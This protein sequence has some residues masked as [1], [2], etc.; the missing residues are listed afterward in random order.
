VNGYKNIMAKINVKDTEVTVIQI[1][2]VNYILLT[3][4]AKFKT[5]EP[6]V[7]I[8]NWMRNRNTIEYLGIWDVCI[9]LILPPEFEGV[10]KSAGL[11]AFT[12]SPQKTKILL[13]LFS[14]ILYFQKN[15]VGTI[16]M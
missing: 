7:V 12:L 3:D 4:I 8:G 13:Q 14:S 11:N 1:N 10:K 9:I 16:L 6:N 15:S 5:S 2:A